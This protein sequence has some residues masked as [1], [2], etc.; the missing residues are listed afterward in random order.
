MFDTKI[1]DYKLEHIPS[2][3]ICLCEISNYRW[4]YIRV[5]YQVSQL[6][7]SPSI[8]WA[9][10][11]EMVLILDGY[12]KW[13][14]LTN[15]LKHKTLSKNNSCFLEYLNIRTT[16]SRLQLTRLPFRRPAKISNQNHSYPIIPRRPPNL[17]VPIRHLDI[18]GREGMHR[19]AF[20]RR[21]GEKGLKGQKLLTLVVCPIENSC[22]S[23]SNKGRFLVLT[24]LRPRLTSYDLF[25]QFI[26]IYTERIYH[27]LDILV[28][29][30]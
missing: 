12:S 11:V 15:Y 13:L 28:N 6:Y 17:A 5:R 18:L 25:D 20:P 9:Y 30:W 26:D 2:I 8:F 29:I 24:P 19:F 23:P 21:G 4:L 27:L 7:V 22:F 14:I 3:R 1:F 10:D 16:Q